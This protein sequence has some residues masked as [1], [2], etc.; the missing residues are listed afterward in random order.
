MPKAALRVKYAAVNICWQGTGSKTQSGRLQIVH[1]RQGNQLKQCELF[2][3]APNHRWDS[4]QA[5]K[6]EHLTDI[7]DDFEPGDSYSFQCLIRPR[8]T[9]TVHQ[10]R[11]EMELECFPSLERLDSLR[12]ERATRAEL[13]KA[14]GIGT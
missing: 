1:M 12:S 7:I 14:Y 8:Q 6:T 4:R 13:G 11:Y 10:L 9:L 3:P 5:K 2:G